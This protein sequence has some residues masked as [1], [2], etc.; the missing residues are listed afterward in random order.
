MVA[1]CAIIML[2]KPF[3]NVSSNNSALMMK[4]PQW[5]MAE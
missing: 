4:F 2:S 1:F 5:Q 3:A